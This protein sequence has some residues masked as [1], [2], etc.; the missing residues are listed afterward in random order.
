MSYACVRCDGQG[1]A[2]LAMNPGS[3]VMSALWNQ[4]GHQSQI[5]AQ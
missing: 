1:E 4:Q 3:N 2:P 5:V